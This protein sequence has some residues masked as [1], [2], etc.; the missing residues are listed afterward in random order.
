MA[1]GVVV[2]NDEQ[3]ATGSLGRK[4]HIA[5]ES[6]VGAI[7]VVTEVLAAQ[8]CGSGDQAQVGGV[9]I[10]EQNFE[11]ASGFLMDQRFQAGQGV[12]LP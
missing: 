10:G 12:I 9:V 6:Q 8:T 3:L 11:V 2:E 4:I 5:S 7:A 1:V